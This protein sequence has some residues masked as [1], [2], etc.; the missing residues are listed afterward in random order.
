MGSHANQSPATTADGDWCGHE[1]EANFMC[2]ED[3][4]ANGEPT[5]ACAGWARLRQSRKKA[6]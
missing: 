1:G 3:L 4:D 6:A 5:K 2:H